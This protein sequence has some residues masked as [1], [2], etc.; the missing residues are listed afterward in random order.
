M[1][2]MQQMV[3]IQQMQQMQ[4]MMMPWQQQQ[5]R[6]SLLQTVIEAN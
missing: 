6:S 5:V 1:Q 2:Q 4:Q 3:W